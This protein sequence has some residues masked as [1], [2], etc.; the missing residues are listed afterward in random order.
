MIRFK[1]WTIGFALLLLS[2]ILCSFQLVSTDVAAGLFFLAGLLQRIAYLFLVKEESNPM[3]YSN[4][5]T[6]Q[7]Y[8]YQRYNEWF[9]LQLAT[10][11]I[12][13]I[14]LPSSTELDV[15]TYFTCIL[16][17]VLLSGIQF[18]NYS[19]LPKIISN[20]ALFQTDFIRWIWVEL[21]SVCKR[22]K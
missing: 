21:N 4:V 16:G 10:C 11:S 5:L 8:V 6:I 7:S 13:L 9:M 19:F 14:V 2:P 17:Y 15:N 18:L 20:H 1:A 22:K 3:H 12:V